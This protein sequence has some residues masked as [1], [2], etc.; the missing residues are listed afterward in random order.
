MRTVPESLIVPARFSGPP[1]AANGG[2]MC[3]VVAGL[4][5][6]ET[7]EVSLRSPAPLGRRLAVL[8]TG[9]AVAVSDEETLVAEGRPGDLDIDA[10]APIPV[11]EARAAMLAGE[12]RWFAHHPFPGCVVCGPA[13]AAGDG[14]RVFPGKVGE[15]LF[16]AVWEPDVSLAGEDGTVLPECVWAALDCP[17]AAPVATFGEGRPIVLARFTARLDGPV[18]TGEEH[19][20]LSW[21]LGRDGRKRH[22][23]CALYDSRGRL[24]ATSRALWIELQP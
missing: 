20:L 16:A 1:G 8:R 21:P 17:T 22:G 14:Y 3:G 13:R 4:L 11:P 12:G 15:G 6:A 18:A 24:L 7:A 19:V 2:Y 10:P 9:D 5:E 23:A